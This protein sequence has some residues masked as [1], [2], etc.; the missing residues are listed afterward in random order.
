M[1]R[2]G[3]RCAGTSRSTARRR[4]AATST[5]GSARWR[6]RAF[7]DGC[8][9]ATPDGGYRGKYTV[10]G[11]A[12]YDI[13]VRGATLRGRVVDADSGA[14]I[15]DA[16]ISLSGKGATAFSNA[17]SDSDGRFSVP[18]L[19]DGAYTLSVHREMYSPSSQPVQISGGVAA[20]VEVRLEG[21][22]AA[23]IIVTDAMTGIALA[24]A[25]VVV[26]SS[27][28]RIG[29]G[30]ARGDDGARVWLRPGRYT[31]TA[32]AF[33]YTS[34]NAELSVPGPPVRIA[35][36]HAGSLVV[37]AKSSGAARLRGGMAVPPSPGVGG[38][39][40]SVARLLMFSPGMNPAIENLNPGQ[41]MLDVLDSSKKNVIKSVPVTIV[42]G[43]KTTVTLD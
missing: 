33:G 42:P 27:G 8:S 29:G 1:S 38:V 32:N 7:P 40:T 6:S 36:A 35:L 13:D 21:G 11:S 3:S 15:A 37:I 18:A 16:S 31:A 17:T 12:T 10:T 26:D 5:S 41:Y 22:T 9:A 23:T 20:D 39:I 25:N 24:N 2:K 14:P 4:P 43:E 28:K 19:L 34:G 30:I